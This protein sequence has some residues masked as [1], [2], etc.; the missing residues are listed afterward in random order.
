[1]EAIMKAN[2]ITNANQIDI[3]DVLLIPEGVD[4]TD[5]NNIN[6]IE[7]LDKTKLI[8]EKEHPMHL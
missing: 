6:F 8:T 2:G 1:M 4:Y 3:G 5:L 7:N